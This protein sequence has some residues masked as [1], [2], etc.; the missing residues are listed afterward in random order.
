M[1]ERFARMLHELAGAPT[2]LPAAY[3]ARAGR[4]DAA[5]AV[6]LQLDCM[7][8]ELTPTQRNALHGLADLLEDPA[9][10]EAEIRAAARKAANSLGTLRTD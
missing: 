9:A 2:A 5:D 7:Q 8:Q 10:P 3:S 1:I 6:R 4:A